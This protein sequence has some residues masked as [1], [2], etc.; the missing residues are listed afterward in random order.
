MHQPDSVRQA[1]PIFKGRKKSNWS[2]ILLWIIGVG[3]LVSI[4]VVISISLHVGWQLTHPEAQPVNEHPGT[5][6]LTFQ[7]VNTT[8][9]LDGIDL[10]GWILETE[11]DPQGLIILAHGYEN[12]RLQDNVPGL[13]VAQKLLEAG[14]HVWMF[15]FRNSGQS[16]GNMTTVGL[17]EKD[18][19]VSVVHD[20]H[21]RYED[22]PIGVLGFS[23]GGATAIIAAA[24]EPLISA[25]IA[26]STFSNLNEYLEANLSLWS[27]LP[28]FPF[29]PIILNLMPVFTF[30]P[31]PVD[32]KGVIQDI[33]IPVLLIHGLADTTIPA[34]NS[35]DIYTNGSPEYIQLW[36]VESGTH[37]RNYEED[38]DMYMNNVIHFL[39]ES[40]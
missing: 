17:H 18:D 7:N 20:A 40:F 5:Y 19:L 22:L 31:S 16:G 23:M 15:D 1:P 13:A 33:D 37:V 36:Q 14:Y 4:L 12:N 27:E 21:E 39:Q 24:E 2:K 38:P 34:Q 29:T 11:H 26:D 6:G 35:M 8:S 25:V 28:D 3:L 9:E 10:S 30:D 32:P